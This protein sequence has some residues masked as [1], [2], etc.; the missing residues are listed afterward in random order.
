MSRYYELGELGSKVPKLFGI[1]TGTKLDDMFY[2]IEKTEEGYVKRSLGGIPH[3]AV[4][5]I[6]GVPDTGKSIL[7]EQFAV[8]QA[9]SGYRVLF[10]TVESPAVF[11]YS[12]IKQRA[13]AMDVDFSKIEKKHNRN[14]CG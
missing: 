10:V 13:D 12:A 2:S 8:K 9:S 3:L 6:T 14:R 11:L 7:A 5:N 4:L 1:P